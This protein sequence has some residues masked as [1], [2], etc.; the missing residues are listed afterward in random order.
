MDKFNVKKKRNK[1]KQKLTSR[2]FNTE[3]KKDRKEGIERENERQMKNGQKEVINK[4]KM[5]PIKKVHS[6][7]RLHR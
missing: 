1:K 4:V 5:F 7:K 3:R 6:F 2:V